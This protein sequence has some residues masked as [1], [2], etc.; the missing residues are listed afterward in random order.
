[1]GGLSVGAGDALM[2]STPLISGLAWAAKLSVSSL[3]SDS[4]AIGRHRSQEL[5]LSVPEG[6]GDAVASTSVAPAWAFIGQ[7]EGMAPSA[8]DP[9]PLIA[10]WTLMRSPAHPRSGSKTIMKMMNRRFTPK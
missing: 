8:C 5:Q 2:K 6:A 9:R 7:S 1:M 4:S 10:I 3:V